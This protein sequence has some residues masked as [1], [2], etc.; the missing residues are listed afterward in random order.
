MSLEKCSIDKIVSGTKEEKEEVEDF[1][2]EKFSNP[3]IE[4]IERLEFKKSAEQIETINL[5]NDETNKL[6]EKYGLEKFDIGPDNIHLLDKNTYENFRENRKNKENKGSAVFK[7]LNQSIIIN[8]DVSFSKTLFVHRLFHEMIH[9]KSRQEIHISK[10][11]KAVGKV[12]ILINPKLELE[13]DIK[14]EDEYFN[15]L[16]EA[17]TEELS[18]RF[19]KNVIRNH[20]DFEEENKLIEEY[21]EKRKLDG[22]NLNI[23]EFSAVLKKTFYSAEADKKEKIKFSPQRA[24]YKKQRIIFNTLVDKLY[25]KNQDKFEDREEVFDLFAK[26]IFTGNIV[27]RGSWGR[28]VDE[29]FGSGTLQKIAE[30]DYDLK[31]LKDLIEDLD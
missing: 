21:I 25:D 31:E 10:D 14:K 13:A 23:D 29:T 18:V 12:G 3:K 17:I 4:K 15:N 5:V 8:Q 24:T 27:S 6:L 30:K 11:K 19:Q 2:S 28:L 26:S 9:F 16:C 1:F 22:V 7:I 20:P